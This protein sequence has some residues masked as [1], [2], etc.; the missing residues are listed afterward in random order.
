MCIHQECI[1]P[2]KHMHATH[3]CTQCFELG[4]HALRAEGGS[5]QGLGL[6]SV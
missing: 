6:A 2:L 1:Q 3:K 5:R 4:L